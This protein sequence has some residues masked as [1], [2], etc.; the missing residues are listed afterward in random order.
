MVQDAPMLPNEFL[1]KFEFADAEKEALIEAVC[2]EE[3]EKEMEKNEGN[4]SETSMHELDLTQAF[5]FTQIL[6]ESTQQVLIPASPQAAYSYYIH[7]PWDRKITNILW[8]K[9]EK[10]IY[11]LSEFYL[12]DKLTTKNS[13][14]FGLRVYESVGGMKQGG[15]GTIYY[16]RFRGNWKSSL[17]RS[18]SLSDK[19]NVDVDTEQIPP[20]CTH[21]VK[22][23]SPK[24]P[25]EFHYTRAIFRRLNSAIANKQLPVDIGGLHP[26]GDLL[27]VKSLGNFAPLFVP[28]LDF[29]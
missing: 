4:L 28:L 21:V 27:W 6:T 25:L 15:Y 5:N 20:C 26:E 24:F 23:Q 10:S 11:N 13:F 8:S 18:S 14:R 3:L 22:C 12:F 1:T 19:E 16:V 29:F 7:D 17:N 9:L 2:K